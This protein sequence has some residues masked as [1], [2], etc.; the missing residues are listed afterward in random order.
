MT[1]GG[2]SRPMTGVVEAGLWGLVAGGALLVGAAVG[3]GVR[4]PQ[5][6]IASVTAF[7]A[8]APPIPRTEPFGRLLSPGE[9]RLS[10]PGENL[11][12]GPRRRRVAR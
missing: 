6:V 3:F 11:R 5:W 9:E 7:G 8:G 10:P 4:V 1:G 2:S 12:H